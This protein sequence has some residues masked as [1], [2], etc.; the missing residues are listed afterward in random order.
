MNDIVFKNGNEVKTTSKIIADV[1]GKTHRDVTKA[2]R[3][4]ECSDEFRASNFGQSSYLS[5]QNKR[6]KCYDITKDGFFFLAMGF[7]GKAAAKWKES[8]INAFNELDKQSHGYVD[9]LLEAQKALDTYKKEGSVFGKLG[10][11]LKKRK[12]LVLAALDK[13]EKIC[14]TEMMLEFKDDKQESKNNLN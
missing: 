11:E 10:V 14:Q 1:F 4:M 5:K 7:T 6:L 9:L 12:P 2:I 8:F 3:V 13:A